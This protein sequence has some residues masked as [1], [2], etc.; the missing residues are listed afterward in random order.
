MHLCPQVGLVE[1]SRLGG[2]CVNVGCVPKKLMWCAASLTEE[3]EDARDYGVQATLQV[4]TSIFTILIFLLSR[5][6]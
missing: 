5:V 4:S 2:T 6:R 3:L 1:A